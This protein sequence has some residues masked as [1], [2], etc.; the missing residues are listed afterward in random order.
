MP[1]AYINKK[2]VQAARILIKEEVSPM[3]SEFRIINKIQ[4]GN[5]P[6]VDFEDLTPEQKKEV[7]RKLNQQALEAIGYRRVETTA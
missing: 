2:P 3:S 6:E 1:R 4:I 7:S 5:Q